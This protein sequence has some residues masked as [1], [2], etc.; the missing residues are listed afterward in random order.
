[1][2]NPMK[3]DMN[4]RF[5]SILYTQFKKFLI[6]IVSLYI[7]HLNYLIVLSNYMLCLI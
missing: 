4:Y 1:M 6:Y 3:V 5:L 2:N 7:F